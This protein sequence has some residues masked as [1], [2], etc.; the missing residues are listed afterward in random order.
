MTERFIR[1]VVLWVLILL[2]LWIGYDYVYLAFSRYT[3]EPRLVTPRASLT[4]IEQATI[5]IFERISPSVAFIMT[6]TQEGGFFP[7]SPTPRQIGTGSGF[8][9]DEAGHIVTN[10]HVIE[11]ARRIGVRF[12]SEELLTA[13]V[14]GSA[15]DYDLAV[16]RISRARRLF[17]PLPI[18]SSEELRVGQLAYAIGNPFGLSRTLTKGIVSA[19]DRRLPTASGREI[20]GVIQTD[21][22][23]NPGNSGGPLLDSAGRLIGVSTAI[24]S[25]TGSFAG[26]GFAVPIDIVNRVVPQLIKEGKVP[27]PGIGIAALPEEV[28]AR[29]DVQGVIIA[30]VVPHSPADKAGLKGINLTT[31]EL[32]DIITHVNGRRV[33]SVPELAAEL[34]EIGIGNQADLTV[35]RRR[36]SR[37]VSVTIQDIS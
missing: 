10:H 24:L 35:Q 2:S 3:A 34:A 26:V 18:G 31:N 37:I 8:I 28:A 23:T 25:G 27:R 4:E 9:W 17:S 36:E 29:F 15:P 20:R 6:E 33:R 12:G 21:A 1:A 13:K 30:E 22:A 19:L 7:F 14:I 11:G 16:L 5:E 32:G